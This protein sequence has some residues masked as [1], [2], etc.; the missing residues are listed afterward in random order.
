MA[1]PRNWP[2]NSSR[3]KATSNAIGLTKLELP[4]AG[5]SE[6]GLVWPTIEPTTSRVGRVHWDLVTVSFGQARRAENW[7]LRI[8]PDIPFD[9]CFAR[10]ARKFREMS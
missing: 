9:M 7:L 6:G 1:G 10:S 5:S 3:E 4:F 2:A 8:F